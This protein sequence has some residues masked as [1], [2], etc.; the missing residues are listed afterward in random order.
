MKTSFIFTPFFLTF[1]IKLYF[2]VSKYEDLISTLKWDSLFSCFPYRSQIFTFNGKSVYLTFRVKVDVIADA[3][4]YTSLVM[5]P[6]QVGQTTF[7]WCVRRPFSAPFLF[8]CLF[9]FSNVCLSPLIIYF[10][11]T[12]SLNTLITNALHS[13]SRFGQKTAVK[14][15]RCQRSFL[16]F[17]LCPVDAFKT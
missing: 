17:S 14:V 1:K 16:N 7:A 2:C 5:L 10:I 4:Y 15:C 9:F 11:S 13:H 12:S 3:L 6:S 8:F